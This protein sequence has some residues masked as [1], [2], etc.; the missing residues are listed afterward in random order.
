MAIGDDQLSC[1]NALEDNGFLVKGAAD[2]DGVK[3]GGIGVIDR[4]DLRSILAIDDGVG[5]D[6]G[7]IGFGVEMEEDI[8]KSA[9]PE[10]VIFVGERGFE[11]DRAGGDIDGIGDE[12]EGTLGEGMGVDGVESGDGEWAIGDGALDGGEVFFGDGKGDVDGGDLLDRGHGGIGVIFDEVPC[13][14]I[15]RAG[16][17]VD[18]GFDGGVAEAD[19]GDFD[20]GFVGL[21]GGGGGDGGGAGLVEYA[22]GNGACGAEFGGSVGFALG[23][24]G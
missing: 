9:W 24:I 16:A 21:N 23:I 6:D 4:E 17:A 20:D 19:G 12:S 15:D 2:C 7:E 11:D 22:C 13:L 3:F 1:R 8:D 5:G 10:G 14:D 18:G